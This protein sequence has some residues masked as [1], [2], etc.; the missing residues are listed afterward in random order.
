MEYIDCNQSVNRGRYREL[1]AIAGY[2]RLAMTIHSS[3]LAQ[4]HHIVSLYQ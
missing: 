3:R 2:N 1:E 4:L